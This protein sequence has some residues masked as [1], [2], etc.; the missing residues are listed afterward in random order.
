MS[1][2]FF[3]VIALLTPLM[4]LL[5]KLFVVGVD[6]P[7]KYI[8][9]LTGATAIT[10]LYATTTISIVKKI[11]NLVK[12]RRTVGLFSFFYALL[13][14]L[15]FIIF[16]ME[17]DLGFAISETIDKPFIYLGMIAFLI[18]LFMAVTSLRVLFSKYFKYHKVIYIAIILVTIHF[19]MAQK[20]L[21][22]EQ[23]GYL[24]IMGIIIVFKVL[25]RTN[26]IKT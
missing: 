2:Q 14:L 25:Q 10:L 12:Y 4:F 20:T 11:K 6:D 26:L 24:F 23:M 21:S 16:D 3:L 7:I 19:I 9:T 18:L 13:H 15:N 1:K 5:Y 22:P 17:L 8:Y